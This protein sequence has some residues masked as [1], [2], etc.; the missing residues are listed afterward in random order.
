MF[1]I[2][3][4]GFT[5]WLAHLPKQWENEI[6]AFAPNLRTHVLKKSQPADLLR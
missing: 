3:A 5:Y 4:G 6:R 2:V 1:A